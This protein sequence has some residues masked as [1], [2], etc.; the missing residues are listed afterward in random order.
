MLR[1]L[2]AVALATFALMPS[3]AVRAAESES[4]ASIGTGPVGAVLGPRWAALGHKIV[5][6]SRTPDADKVKAL[7]KDSPKA[8]AATPSDAVKKATVVV[9]AVPG[10]AAKEVAAGLGDLKGK[11]VID[12]TNLFNFKNGMWEPEGSDSVVGQIQAAQPGAF[13]VKAF[14]TVTAIVMKNPAVTGF[15]VTVPLA[16]DD[17]AAKAKVSTL[18]KQLGFETIDIGKLEMG[19]TVEHLGR[20][21][22]YY[23]RTH[24]ERLEFN[25]RT[26]K[27]P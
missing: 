22:V 27:Q 3:A 1:I 9:I 18:A 14:N 16:G 11:V 8:T 2:T 20:L 12:T 7:L 4:I 23:G 10:G 6:G 21:Y 26:W 13:V 17:A 5:Y 15:P 25:F 19:R 24:P